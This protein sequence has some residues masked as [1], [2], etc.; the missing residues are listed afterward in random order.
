MTP[1]ESRMVSELFDRLA[2][3]EGAHRDPDAERAVADGFDRAPNAAYALVQTV[4]VQDEALKRA[5][6]RIEEL[7]SALT[8]GAPQQER[9]GFLDNMREALSGR[10][11]SRGSV[12]S[13]RPGTPA[14]EGSS[15]RW[16][17]GGH[18]DYAGTRPAYEPPAAPP[19]GGAGAPYGGAGAPYGGGGGGGAGSFLGTAAASAAGV[20]GGALLMNSIRG[21]FGS[22]PGGHA[23]SAF[24]PGLSGEGRSP[25]GGGA[26]G[27]DLARDAGLNDIGSGGRSGADEGERH[28][29]LF[30]DDPA[31]DGNDDDSGDDYGDDS[32]G[33][34]GGSDTA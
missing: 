25:W 6:A 1:Q 5:N 7:E 16:N 10:E 27:S 2:T 3:L 8:S 23:S 14:G 29:G 21:M 24:D 13:V 31:D 22:S 4:L 26:S 28:A 17:M 32:G 30:G 11:A 19:Y 9:G 18:S 34:F 20:I 15:G 33:D 12:P